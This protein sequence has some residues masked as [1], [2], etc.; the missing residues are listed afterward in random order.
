[1]S[2]PPGSSD[3]QLIAYRSLRQAIGYIGV[4]LPFVLAIGKSVTQGGGLQDSI[5]AYYYTDMR[6]VFVGSLCAIGVFLMCYRGYNPRDLGAGRFAFV[7]AIGVAFCPTTPFPD[8]TQLQRIVGRLHLTFATLLFL[9]FAYFCWFLFTKTD[10]IK[11]PTPKKLQRNTVYKVC[12]VAIVAC[13]ALIAILKL[14][15]LEAA[16]DRYAPV[17]WLESFTIL[18]FGISWL[19]KGERILKD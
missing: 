19:T 10:P 3:P 14:T 4:A 11:K 15:A 17:F 18:A 2:Q 9:T 5:S 1:M 16:T 6:N 8:A 7:C 13:I 12:A